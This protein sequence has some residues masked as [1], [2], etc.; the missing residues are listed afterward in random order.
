MKF[1]LTEV[2]VSTPRLKPW[3]IN[4]VEFAGVDYKEGTSSSGNKWAAMQF[5]FKNNE[6]TY[7]KM[8]FCP[9]ANGFER[10]S[11]DT[12]GR[13]WT[14]PADAEV[15]MLQIQYI[16]TTLAPEAY[17]KVAGKISVDLPDEFNKLY[18]YVNKI[19]SKA[20][21]KTVGLKLVADSRGYADIPRNVARISDDGS[22][23]MANRWLGDNLSFS[24]YELKQ[25]DAA[26]NEKPSNVDAVVSTDATTD[27]ND[28]D[29]NLL[30][31]L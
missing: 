4:E 9:T 13:A 30:E 6:G 18:E 27:D 29:L 24:A 23:Y 12:N 31:D 16:C 7:S 22:V 3:T 17:A 19:L 20:I 10:R 1:S 5:N 26:A 21:G 14:L 2:K 28:L 15:L 25:K 11:G 8:L